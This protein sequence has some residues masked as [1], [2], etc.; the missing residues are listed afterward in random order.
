MMLPTPKQ[1]FSSVCQKIK[2]QHC[3][4]WMQCLKCYG[5][6]AKEVNSCTIRNR[7]IDMKLIVG[8]EYLEN[9]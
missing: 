7:E 3:K 6:I 1:H 5:I 9:E 2:I 4:A 8:R